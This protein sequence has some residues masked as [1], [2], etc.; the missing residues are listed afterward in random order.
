MAK[1]AKKEQEEPQ[2]KRCFIITPIGNDNSETR[3]K[4]DGLIKTVIRP[5]LD[6]LDIACEAAHEISAPG[7]ITNQVIKRLLDD[8]IV[9]A[10][11]TELNP[12]VMYEL[13][14]R[15][16]K[17][18]PVVV[19]AENG[20]KL[21]FDIVTER[22]LF[23]SNDLK[24]AEELKPMLIDAVEEALND[25]EVDNPIYRVIEDKLIRE[26]VLDKGDDAQKL[27]FEK[28]EE[29]SKKVES[30]NT[31]NKQTYRSPINRSNNIYIHPHDKND[32]QRLLNENQINTIV[33]IFDTK[34]VMNEK[35]YVRLYVTQISILHL[36]EKDD[37][38]GI[39]Q[40][41][42]KHYGIRYV[43]D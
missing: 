15:H 24:G 37:I 18:K 20:T 36:Q 10:N 2:Q 11:L 25:T 1:A 39:A 13:A 12:N 28:I 40:N 35:D 6:S 42:L 4:A 32:A 19:L 7:S 9:I 17:G 33:D 16:A 23:Y 27:I 43:T 5:V 14:V 22:T 3:R 34:P 41:I 31:K 26:T 8:D 38:N 30:L 21:P 29:L